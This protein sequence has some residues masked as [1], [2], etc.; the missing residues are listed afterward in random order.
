MNSRLFVHGASET[1]ATLRIA[2][3]GAVV[4]AEEYDARKEAQAIAALLE[5]Y[6]PRQTFERLLELFA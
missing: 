6:L 4:C 2:C 3:E 1:G 5:K